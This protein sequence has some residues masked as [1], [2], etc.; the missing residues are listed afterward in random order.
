[1]E[2]ENVS[3]DFIYNLL[4]VKKKILRDD[5]LSKEIQKRNVKDLN[6]ILKQLT[7]KQD[8]SDKLLSKAKADV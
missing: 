2:A 6:A 7:K 1:M 5:K 4:M 8:Q 3:F